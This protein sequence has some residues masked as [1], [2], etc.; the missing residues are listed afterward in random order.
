[1][2]TLRKTLETDADDSLALEVDTGLLNKG[3]VEIKY[4]LLR[5]DAVYVVK[6]V[7]DVRTGHLYLI[8]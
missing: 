3:L 1:L 2:K 8:Q 6:Y 7:S 5:C 4:S